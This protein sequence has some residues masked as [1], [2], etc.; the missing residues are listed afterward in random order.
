MLELTN[1]I[2]FAD[3]TSTGVKIA[4]WFSSG[5]LLLY[6]VLSSGLEMYAPQPS[7]KQQKYPTAMW[8][9]TSIAARMTKP[10]NVIA[11]HVVKCRERST[12]KSDEN[13]TQSKKTEPTMFGATV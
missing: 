12:Q 6:H 4:R 10:M 3:A 1:P 2:A 7:K 13:A 5:V 8:S 11:I 9:L